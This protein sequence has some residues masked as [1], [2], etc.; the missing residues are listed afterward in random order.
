[1]KKMLILGAFCSIIPLLSAQTPGQ[2]S[3]ADINAPPVKSVEEAWSFLP[4]IVAVVDDVNIEKAQIMASVRQTTARILRPGVSLEQFPAHMLS[5]YVE[6]AL[7]GEIERMM[8]LR[9]AKAGNFKPSEALADKA[10]A[11]FK[12]QIMKQRESFDKMPAE[13]R[14]QIAAQLEQQRGMTV[15]QVIKEEMES[16]QKDVR[17]NAKDPKYQDIMAVQIWVDENI[18]S[19]VKLTDEEVSSYYEENKQRF[20]QKESVTASHILITP[21]GADPRGGKAATPEAKVEAKRVVD[22]ILAEL[23][24]GADFGELAVA[25][26]TGPSAP[27]KGSLGTFNRGQ[28]VPAF[29][30]A[31]FSMKPGDVS[32]VVETQFGYH[33]IKVTAR[34]DAKITSLEEVKDQLK[35]QL[36]GQKISEAVRSVA[37]AERENAKIDIKFTPAPAGMPMMMP[38]K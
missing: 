26:S 30:E 24:A 21:E 17:S 20:E 28:M 23:K 13:Q 35:M 31:A 34:A 10:I 37:M 33:I 14:A 29:E 1:M 6:R 3:P 32:D 2:I 5:Q 15:D 22:G 16:M 36:E 9:L 38:Q 18:I 19:K 8:L 11:L 7:D 12:K 25:K 27:Q 4:D